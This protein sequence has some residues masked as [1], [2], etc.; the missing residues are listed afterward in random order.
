[1]DRGE[2]EVE[3]ERRVRTKRMPVLPTDSEKHESKSTHVAS[4]SQCKIEDSRKLLEIE[5]SLPRVV[6]GPWIPCSQYGRGSGHDPTMS[7]Q[8]PHNAAEAHQV[9]HEA[10]EPHAVKC[11]L[12]DLDANGL[13]R[14]LPKGSVESAAQTFVVRK[15][16]EF[17]EDE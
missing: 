16:R 9:S 1:M 15:T 12:E 17:S 11:A 7:I 3:E 10:P 2:I 14:V 4:G 13:G 5:S 8:K 6:H